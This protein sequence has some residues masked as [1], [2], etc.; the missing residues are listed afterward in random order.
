[1]PSADVYTSL[2]LVAVNGA[3]LDAQ[4]S[5]L[6]THGRVTDAAS[7]PDGFDLEFTDSAG[8]LLTKARIQIGSTVTI[9]VSE[10]GPESPTV[11]VDGEVT[12]LEREDIGGALITRV[13]GLDKSH[14]LFRGRRVRAFID[15]TIS[16]VV[17]KVATDAGITTATVS[18]T[19]QVYAKISQDNVSDW[20]F[21]KRLSDMVGYSFSV[22]QGKLS[23][24]KPTDAADAPSGSEGAR[25]D[26]V[27]IEH[28]MNTLYLHSTIT[29]AEQVP[30][31]EV[32]GWN[33]KD[34]KT[35][36]S[37]APAKTRSAELSITPAKIADVFKSPSYVL[38]VGDGEAKSQ[39]G[40]AA[41]VAER[42]AGGFAELEALVL[43]T[44]RIRSGTA[45]KLKG[46]GDPF[47]G[48][49]SVTETVHDFS[50][51]VGYTTKAIVSNASDRSLYGITTAGGLGAAIGTS[52][53][54]G[55]VPAVVTAHG[56]SSGSVNADGMVKVTF[57][58]LSDDYESSWARP[59]QLGAGGD[60]GTVVLPEVGDEVLVAF[61][62]GSL[63]RPFV[64]G[65]LYN[66]K[67]LPK[68]GWAASVKSGTPFR[69]SFTS[70]TGM[71]VELSEDT[72]SEFVQIST[73]EGAQRVTLTQ[74][75]SKGIE[76]I[77]EGPV[78]VT[79][80]TDAT[81]TADSGTITL[82]GKT[83]EIKATTDLKLSAGGNV[84]V[85]GVGIK[86]AGTGKAEVSG[87]SLSLKAQATAELSGSA[88]TTISGGMVKI[89]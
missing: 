21:L 11:L 53:M 81:V 17:Q 84:D 39:D 69:R 13:R 38:S 82:S 9:S 6:L 42:I 32:R 54:H 16:D 14:R 67:D 23:F 35:V 66:G 48:R 74:T 45:V 46:F 59:V 63:D 29:S 80:K 3:Q 56:D 49:Y 4:L 76:I 10:N 83:V 24:E 57:P 61:E 34:K 43:G 19:S 62:N 78:Q 70:R 58:T 87:A 27:V 68:G 50:P 71:L 12:A 22:S 31:V 37:K 40:L 65:G 52:P 8:D 41:A 25:S 77:S 26:P 44:A 7:L 86:L 75:A 51:E 33:V 47:D 15:S 1:M 20:V 85:Q 88:M 60:R 36:L 18:T 30:Q 64:L 28:G 55:V 89:N 2:M 5:G 73:N 72:G 79:A